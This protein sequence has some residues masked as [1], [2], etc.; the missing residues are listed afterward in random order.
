MMEEDDQYYHLELPI[1]AVRCV[2]KGLTQA[3]TKWSGGEPQEQEDLIVM[4]DL[5][6]RIILTHTF[7]NVE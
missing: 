7:D 1:D 3:V 6:Y 2:H 5:F 4:R